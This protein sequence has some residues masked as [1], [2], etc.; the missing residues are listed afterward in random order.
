MNEIYLRVFANKS[1]L[2]LGD[3]R[4]EIFMEGIMN[5]STKQKQCDNI[6]SPD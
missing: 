3:G 1:E 6:I 5:Q 4:T 2:V